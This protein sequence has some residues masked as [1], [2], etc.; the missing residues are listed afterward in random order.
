MNDKPQ[1]LITGGTGLV[2]S[3]LRRFIIEQ[4]LPYRIG[5]LSR[6][7]VQ[8]PHAK[9][10]LWDIEKE[11]IDPKALEESDYIIHLAGAGIADKPWTAERKRL[12]LESRTRSTALLYKALKNNPHRVKHFVSASAVG[13]YGF[14]TGDRLLHEDSPPG[15]DFLAQVVVAWEKEIFRIAELMPAVALRIGIVLSN[16]GGALP[17]LAR[18]VRWFVGAPLGSGKQYL[19]W[20]HIRDLCRLFLYALQKPLDTGVYNA[21]E[22]KP[23]TNAEMTRIIARVLGRP[24]WL[25]KVPAFVLKTL[26][27]EMA[28]L[29]LG[30]NRVS[31]EKVIQS[32]FSYEFTEPEAALR[33]LL[34]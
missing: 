1:I 24:L 7:P 34:K 23:V 17:Q 5:V 25:P 21:V 26:L 2:G 20:I 27:G 30:G 12:I 18:P 28:N 32:G 11:Q 29:V 14:D 33:D 4:Q 6:R 19:S 8:L 15:N 13:Y 16:E 31:N 9:T 22:G 3:Y 10:Y